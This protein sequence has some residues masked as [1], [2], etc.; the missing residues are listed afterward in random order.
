MSLF[1]SAE[2]VSDQIKPNHYLSSREAII[3]KQHH[4]SSSNT[5]FEDQSPSQTHHKTSTCAATD[6]RDAAI[7]GATMSADQPSSAC[8]WHTSS[9]NVKRRR[10]LVSRLPHSSQC[11]FLLDP[12]SKY[13]LLETLAYQEKHERPSGW[14][15]SRISG[16]REAG[17]GRAW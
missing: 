17:A 5:N 6:H 2:V 9:R 8:L 10:P 15:R 4:I 12:P 11:L 1:R 7:A 13:M 16:L 3:E 14:T